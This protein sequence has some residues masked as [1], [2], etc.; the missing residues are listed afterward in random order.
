MI[1]NFNF[2]VLSLTI[3]RY[4]REQYV[5]YKRVYADKRTRKLKTK[6]SREILG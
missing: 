1:T 3:T 6:R 4:N 5:D 2:F